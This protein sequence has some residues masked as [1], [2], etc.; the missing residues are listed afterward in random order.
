MPSFGRPACLARARIVVGEEIRVNRYIAVLIPEKR[1]WSVLFPDF[2][3]CST[4]GDTIDEAM[5][6]AG[7]A[8]AGH[9]EVSRELGARIPRPRGVEAIMADRPWAKENAVDWR[10]AMAAPIAVRPAI[11]RPE[12]VTISV[13]SNVLNAIDTYAK[14]R[15]LTRSAVMA[16]GAEFL[17]R[18]DPVR[19]SRRR[20]SG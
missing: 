17:M 19:Q 2:P 1:G 5:D 3:G 11:G 13:D 10:R 18:N 7:D 6:M 12:R 20:K 14:R 4:C 16:A 9:V 15:G 8:L